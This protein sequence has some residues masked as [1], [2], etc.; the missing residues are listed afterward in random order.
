MKKLSPRQQQMLRFL[1]EFLEEHGYPPT[2][3][4]IQH[5]CDVSSTSVVDYNLNILQREGHIRRS[6]EISRG[7][8]LVNR[9]ER[10]RETVSIPLLGYIAAGQPLPVTAAEDWS[11]SDPMATVE[12]A[13]A[14]LKGEQNLF[15]LRVK[16]TSMIDALIDDGDIVVL[17]QTTEARNG[18]MVVAW[19]KKD[20]EATLKRLYREGSRVRL[21]PA[22]S[23]MQPIFVAPS[24]VE[25]QGKVVAVF[26]HLG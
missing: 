26:R 14:L 22:N 15:A 23:Q 25:V 9:P 12:V 17:Q 11:A 24:D 5:A 20:K 10:H 3:R 6:P 21:Q 1:G 16:G 8:E 18:D 4:D 13:S 19:L 2:V 7:I